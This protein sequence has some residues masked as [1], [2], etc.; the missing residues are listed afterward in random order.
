MWTP[1]KNLELN[2]ISKY[3]GEQYLDN[4]SNSNRAIDAYF[5]NDFRIAYSI[6]DVVF[7]RIEFNI[8]VNN[9]F[10]QAYASNGYTY[11]YFYEE[12]AYSY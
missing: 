7:E 1:I 5:I 2:L 12:V 3:V 9:I 10:N 11:S 4:T 8:L 6:E